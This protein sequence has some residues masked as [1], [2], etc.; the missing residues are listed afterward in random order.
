VGG[1]VHTKG[2][3]VADFSGVFD[4]N[5]SEKLVNGTVFGDLIS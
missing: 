3:L 5:A 4:A 2:L 1:K